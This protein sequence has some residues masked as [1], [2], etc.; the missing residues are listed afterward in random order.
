MLLPLKVTRPPLTFTASV[1][2]PSLSC[3][4]TLIAPGPAKVAVCGLP[5]AARV[6]VRFSVPPETW[7]TV[8]GW[9][10]VTGPENVALLAV[11]PPMV[12]VPVVTWLAT[13]T[14]LASV[15]GPLIQSE[16][17]EL[18]VVVSLSPRARV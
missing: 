12:Y 2:E 7:E 18:L 13:V 6:F 11:L 10:I 3:P 16:G 5:L 4:L 15:Y 17:L 14:A 9:F 1:P 8:S